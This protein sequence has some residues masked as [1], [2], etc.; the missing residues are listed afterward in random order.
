MARVLISEWRGW[1]LST[2]LMSF[3]GLA[4]LP[5]YGGILYVDDDAPL[6]GDGQSWSTAYKYLQDALLVA[7][8]DSGVHEIRIAGGVYTPD[9]DEVGHYAPGNPA[10]FFD[11]RSELAIIGGYRGLTAGGNPDDRDIAFFETVL[12]GDLDGNDTPYFQN[13]GDNSRTVLSTSGTDATAIVDGVTISAGFDYVGGSGGIQN[14]SGAPLIRNC[15]FR[16]NQGVWGGGVSSVG[17]G[18]IALI[19]CVFLNNRA[20]GGGGGAHFSSN[21]CLIN[22]A[23][24]ANH[25]LGDGGAVICSGNLS[26]ANCEFIGNQAGLEEIDCDGQPDS[27]GGGLFQSGSTLAVNNCVFSQNFAAGTGGGVFSVGD[28]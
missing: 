3:I 17:D 16:D 4:G 26:C 10:A 14:T 27:H 13:M 12:S 28:R 21:A 11:T 25:A 22:C 2:V 20:T 24:R 19:G 5:V 8:D 23:F 18:E 15:T 1:W 9:K 6:G 7:N